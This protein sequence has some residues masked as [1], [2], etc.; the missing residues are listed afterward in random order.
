MDT[1]VTPRQVI[2]WPNFVTMMMM[3]M[4]M[5]SIII[6]LIMSWDSFAITVFN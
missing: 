2:Y 4:M 1:I 5:I 6:N 3:M